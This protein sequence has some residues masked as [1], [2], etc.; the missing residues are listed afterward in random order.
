MA[1][2]S[3]DLLKIV[4][5]IICV[6]FNDFSIQKLFKWLETKGK[7]KWPLEASLSNIYQK[8]LNTEFNIE[9]S[10]KNI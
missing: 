3:L 6:L 4:G 8:C 7:Y 9:L 10:F 5:H 2:V 1:A